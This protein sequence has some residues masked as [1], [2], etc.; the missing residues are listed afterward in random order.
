MAKRKHEDLATADE[1][2][3]TPDPRKQRRIVFALEEGTKKLAQA[4]KL[5]KGFERQKLGRRRKDA[6]KEKDYRDMR[7][8][9]EEI[10]A[11]KVSENMDAHKVTCVRRRAAS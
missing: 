3:K 6:E 10:A 5:A 8:I 7:R 2:G 1:A 11:A 9:D 4:F